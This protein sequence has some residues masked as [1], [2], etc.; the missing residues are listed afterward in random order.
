MGLPAEVDGYGSLPKVLH[1]LTVVAI[2]FQFGVG[3]SMDADAAADRAQERVDAFED[4]GARQAKDQGEV[5]EERFEAEVERREDAV[6]ALERSVGS[7]ELRDVVT[8]DALRDR[9]TG[10][11]LHV[12]MGLAI[13]A[14]GAARL[15]WRRVASLPPWAEHLSATERTFQAWLEKALLA[16]LLVVPSSGLLLA[17]GGADLL[18]LHIAAQV[19]LVVAVALH[20]GLVL[21]H[22][23]VRRNGHLAR[24]L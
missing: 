2:A 13:L 21:K 1:W 7:R 14:L 12:V 22:T 17:L 10:V 19:A 15:L 4:R 11:E 8:G 16:L 5:A 6:E 24:M 23:V 3:L 20:V 18:P 9:L